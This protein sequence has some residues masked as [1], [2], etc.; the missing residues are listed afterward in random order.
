MD[1]YSLM[2]CGT[3]SRGISSPSD[4]A[5]AGSEEAAAVGRA[6]TDTGAGRAEAT[7]GTREEEKATVDTIRGKEAGAMSSPVKSMTSPSQTFFFLACDSSSLE[8]ETSENFLLR[9][10]EAEGISAAGELVT[11]AVCE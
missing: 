8:S 6:G 2:K 9:G 11:E 5:R 10:E 4:T 7:A 3:A 1:R